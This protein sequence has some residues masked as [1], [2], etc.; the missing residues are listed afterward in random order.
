[1]NRFCGRMKNIEISRLFIAILF[2]F[3]HSFLGCKSDNG[4]KEIN[5]NNV[6]R[7]GELRKI[8]LD[9]AESVYKFGF[10]LRRSLRE[11]V[12]QY[13][14][15]INYLES[16]TGLKF[17]LH[18]TKKGDNISDDIGTGKIQFAAVGA[19]TYIHA[20]E[21]YSPI[22]LVRGV[23]SEGKPEYQ[24]VLFTLP[25][26]D[27]NSVEDIRGKSFAFGS[28]NSTQGHIIPRIILRNKKITLKDLKTYDWM[29]S[30][31]EVANAVIRGDYDVG[32]IQDLLGWELEKSGLIKIIH[33]SKFY[34]SSGIIAYGGVPEE[35][36]SNVMNA[37]LSFESIGKDSANLVNWDKTE[38]ANGFIK[39]QKGDYKELTKWSKEF[40]IISNG[41]KK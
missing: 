39:A 38:M 5:L 23:T 18:I 24:S 33:V 7:N 29:A 31:K 10:D 11:D 9:N 21:K 12:N 40:G 17:E 36:I 37:L 35:V 13:Q 25:K 22:P 32:G 6:L 16:T 8:K 27:I 4:R 41:L 30:H 28:Y 20:S 14:P 34:P 19:G 2:V 3:I 15:F 1:M 26:S